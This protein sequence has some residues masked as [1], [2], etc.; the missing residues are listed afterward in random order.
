MT[1]HHTASHCITML[2]NAMYDTASDKCQRSL[3]TSILWRKHIVSCSSIGSLFGF[4]IQTPSCV[5]HRAGVCTPTPPH[6]HLF[7]HPSYSYDIGTRREGRMRKGGREGGREGGNERG[8]GRDEGGR[9][10]GG[11]LTNKSVLCSLLP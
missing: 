8:G 5:Y 3:K 11:R 7:Q 2:Y 1:M 10:E 9:D 4:R 6:T